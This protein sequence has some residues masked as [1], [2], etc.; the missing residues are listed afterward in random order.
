[1]A[2]LHI[3]DFDDTL[4]RADDMIRITHPD[5]T[6][7][8]LSSEA[9]AKYQPTG[10]EEFDFSDFDRYPANPRII[11]EVFA[12]LRAAIALDGP[13]SVVIL[14]ARSNPEPVRQFLA[15]NNV[16]GIEVHATGAAAAMKKARYILDRVMNEDFDEVRVFEDNAKNIRTIR[17]VV[18]PTGIKLQ[19]N[20]V[21][22]HGIRTESRR[23]STS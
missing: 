20:R 9:Y 8:S 22:K 10:E 23:R 7:E 13:E 18:E 19:T 14:T 15:D 5:G 16:T 17:K 21:T 3:F 2:T 6:H 11:E 1:M 4:I 12:E